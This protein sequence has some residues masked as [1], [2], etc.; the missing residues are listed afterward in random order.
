MKNILEN[1]IIQEKKPSF[2]NSKIKQ[3]EFTIISTKISNKS[4]GLNTKRSEENNNFELNLDNK[5]NLDEG[6]KEKVQLF[7]DHDHP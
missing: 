6:L 5:T 1:P 4:L 2:K 3:I 7:S